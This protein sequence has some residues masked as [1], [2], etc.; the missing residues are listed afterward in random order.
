MPPQY[1]RSSVLQVGPDPSESANR[2]VTSW[3]VG[4][5][6]EE[7]GANATDL[8]NGAAAPI[9]G[10]CCKCGDEKECGKDKS[11]GGDHGWEKKVGDSGGRP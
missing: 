5:S 8:V 11:L 7:E 2:S 10:G 6:T 9:I 4:I 1:L 3:Q